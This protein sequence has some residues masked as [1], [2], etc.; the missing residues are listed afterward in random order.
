MSLLV[1]IRKSYGHF[2]LDVAFETDGDILGLLGA[3]GCGKSVTLKC[4]AGIERPDA[5]RIVL[6]GRVLFDAEQKID[7]PPQERR[8]GYLFQQYALFPTMTVEQNVAAGA[9]RRPRT[10]RSA[11]VDAMLEKMQIADLRRKYPAQLSGGQQQRTALARILINEPEVLL[12]DEPFSALDSHLRDRMEQEVMRV[13]RD[14]GGD[15]LIVSHSR[16]EIYRMADRIAVYNAGRIDAIGEKHELFRDPGTLAAAVLT[17]CKNYSR[18]SGLRHENGC[19]VFTADDWGMELFV[20]GEK[21]GDVVGLRR[22]YAVLA[23]APGPN[24]YEM[25]VAGVL[26][27]PFEYVVLLRRPGFDGEPFG[28]AVTKEEY[29]ALPKD[30][31]CLRFPDRALML[32]RK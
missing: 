28:W 19:T 12:L 3:S 18:I 8:V 4:I 31:L 13:L 24:T 6:N 32:L 30:R 10:E 23:D 5:G 15:T 20:S 14:F 11:A 2:T 1:D 17:G 22:H 7:L 25:E 26:E 27:D 29:A 9:R 21:T 16:D